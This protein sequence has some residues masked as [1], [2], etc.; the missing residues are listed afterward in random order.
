MIEYRDECVGCTS[1]GL[2][3]LGSVCPN[4]NVPYHIC[5]D[6][7]D[8][9]TLYKFEGEELCLDCILERLEVVEG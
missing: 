1:M 8:E 7:G 2:H 9:T 3:C 6:C 5:D 4:R